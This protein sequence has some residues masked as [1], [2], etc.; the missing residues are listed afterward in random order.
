[1][2]MNRFLYRL[3]YGFGMTRW[4]SGETPP[5]VQEAF[6]AGD[7]P[8]GASLDLGCGTGTNTIFMAQQGR[9]AIGL[10]FAPEAI[11]W[12]R[13]KAQQAGVAGRAQFQVADVTRL[14]EMELPRSG[15]ALDMGCF[16]GLSPDGQRRYAVGLAKTLICFPLF[17]LLSACSLFDASTQPGVTAALYPSQ[18]MP[19]PT[20]SPLPTA[21]QTPTAATPTPI[22]AEKT[23]L[24][25]ILKEP[26][27]LTTLTPFPTD[28]RVAQDFSSHLAGISIQGSGD[29]PPFNLVAALAREP[30]CDVP[31]ALYHIEGDSAT[32]LMEFDDK[33]CN[34]KMTVQSSPDG[35]YTAILVDRWD[36]WDAATSLE[37]FDAETKRRLLLDR[38]ISGYRG[39]Y[40]PPAEQVTSA[41]WQDEVHLFYVKTQWVTQE[42]VLKS[43]DEGT[44]LPLK[45]QIWAVDMDGLERRLVASGA[46][47]RVLGFSGDGKL[48]YVTYLMNNAPDEE[49]FSLLHLDTG[50]VDMLWQPAQPPLQGG[51]DMRLV[52]LLD[53]RQGVLY[54]KFRPAS[55]EAENGVWIGNLQTRGTRRLLPLAWQGPWAGNIHWSP[56]QQNAFLYT[57]HSEVGEELW[58][59]KIGGEAELLV[60][61][62]PG[63]VLA[64]LPEGILVWNASKSRLSLLN[65]TGQV[66]GEIHF[67]PDAMQARQPVPAPDLRAMPLII[68]AIPSVSSGYYSEMTWELQDFTLSSQGEVWGR[69]N[70]YNIQPPSNPYYDVLFVQLL[71]HY[72]HPLTG[73]TAIVPV[74]E[75][76]PVRPTKST[77]DMAEFYIHERFDLSPG[78]L[79]RQGEAA[80][81]YLQVVMDWYRAQVSYQDPPY[82]I[83]SLWGK[84]PASAQ[85]G[86]WPWSGSSLL[87]QTLSFEGRLIFENERDPNRLSAYSKWMRDHLYFPTRTPVAYPEPEDTP[88]PSL[89]SYPA[90]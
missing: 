54:A 75:F 26:V 49:I 81:K 14:D 57:L 8:S 41:I 35:R 73:E 25:W 19:V 64:W 18:T 82:G 31:Y 56:V 79:D 13:R 34:S 86:D 32:P 43:L 5:E 4:D 80:L 40:E 58:L 78:M 62:L 65:E 7:I 76:I 66:V 47:Y 55:S 17:I 77:A 83:Y 51:R 88:V 20:E 16:H 15:F 45:S 37:I 9:Q 85:V 87:D 68:G 69:L 48:L 59:S 1:M 46:F 44:P 12:A 6:R 74:G 89:P 30:E 23:S 36:Q 39:T 63:S 28:G 21:T 33:T 53:G 67:A 70:I 52:A 42:E 22:A 50:K 29:F 71:A 38:G 84:I 60:E 90:P 10:D 2:R 61:D 27:I 72:A 3:M 11:H 24:A